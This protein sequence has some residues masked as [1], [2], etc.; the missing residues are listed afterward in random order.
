MSQLKSQA[1]SSM[2]KKVSELPKKK[3][4]EPFSQKSSKFPI[5]IE[6]LK[7]IQSQKD[8]LK[9]LVSSRKNTNLQE[10][11]GKSSI[12]ELKETLRQRALKSNRDNAR[13]D[14][15]ENLKRPG[16]IGRKKLNDMARKIAK[17]KYGNDQVLQYKYMDI[18]LKMF[19][20]DELIFSIDT[21]P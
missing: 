16:R 15:K 4:S 3:G 5:N 2:R 1:S 18:L 6:A 19:K 10:T 20:N 11:L 13:E 9:D 7:S 17:Q 21:I 14:R 8:V 12:S